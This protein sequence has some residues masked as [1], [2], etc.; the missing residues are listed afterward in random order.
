MFF[1]DNSTAGSA[2]LDGGE[3]SHIIFSNQSTAGNATISGGGGSGFIEFSDFSTAG[4][5]IIT[6]N[7]G[8][9]YFYGSSKGGTAQIDLEFNPGLEQNSALD[10]SGHSAPGMTIGSIEG[11]GDVLLGANNLTV[12][13]NNLSTAFSGVI[14]DGGL[15]GGTGGALTK[16]GS[17]TLVL[18]GA[19][20]YTGSTN[21]N[22]GVLQVDGS[23]TSNTFVNHGG[24]LAG[25]GTVNGNVTNNHGGKV[26]PGDVLG[27]P[28]V[29]TVEDNYTQTPSA[30]L[31]IQ[32]E[33]ADAGQVSV[34]DVRGNANLNGFLDPVLLNGFVPAIGQSFSFL[35][36]ASFTGFFS[37]I[38]NAVFDNRRKR[39][40]LVYLPTGAYL[41]AIKNGP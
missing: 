34:L 15:N 22:R 30:A 23:I 6:S 11:E 20:T 12:G 24:A 3:S 7:G 4:N 41:I 5:A 36:Y 21:I 35:N 31:L 27:V 29:L 39:W 14:Q 18:S 28:G 19:N 37:H 13:T 8:Q 33:G 10:I 2:L 38:Q 32:I 40:L 9:I 25:S 17:G 1:F 16:I 26:S